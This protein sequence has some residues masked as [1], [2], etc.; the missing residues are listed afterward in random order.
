MIKGLVFD[1]DGTLVNSN[2]Y[3]VECWQKA[4]EKAGFRVEKIRIQGLIGK[5]ARQIVNEV[6]GEKAEENKKIEVIQEHTRNFEKLIDKVEAFPGLLELF[7]E[8][9]GRGVSIALATSTKAHFVEH[10]LERFQ[11]RELVAAY[12][13]VEE[14]THHKPHPEVFL[15]AAEKIGL[16]PAEVIAVGDSVWDIQAAKRGKIKVVA[17]LTGGISQE[18]LLA[19]KPDWLFKDLIELKEKLD[20]LLAE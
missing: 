10:Y 1:V 19:E 3:H 20:L 15:K 7:Q 6:L 4:F 13:T 17:L 14:V 9:N 2:H 8:I 11:I 18:A 16:Q 12:T 5:G